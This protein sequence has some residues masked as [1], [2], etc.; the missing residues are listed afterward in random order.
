[1]TV[2]PTKNG[3]KGLLLLALTA[4]SK[5]TMVT[6]HVMAI[7]PNNAFIIRP[8][9]WRTVNAPPWACAYF[10]FEVIPWKKQEKH[11]KSIVLNGSKVLVSYSRWPW[12]HRVNLQT[13]GRSGTAPPSSA[14]FHHR[15]RRLW[16][17]P[18]WNVNHCVRRRK[19][20]GITH[21]EAHAVYPRHL[22][23]DQINTSHSGLF[24]FIRRKYKSLTVLTKLYIYYRYLRL[25]YITW[26]LYYSFYLFM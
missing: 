5:T 3:T 11:G 20:H 21:Q 23:T 22:L 13:A 24:L 4:P 19:N 25:F 17:R 9:G 16:W 18:D 14:P 12:L 15:G 10:S 8:S 26:E 2:Q 1:M 6:R 7:S